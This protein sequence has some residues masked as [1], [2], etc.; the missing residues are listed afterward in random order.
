MWLMCSRLQISGVDG[1]RLFR[2]IYTIM[3]EFGHIVAQYGTATRGLQE[4]WDELVKLERDLRALMCEVGLCASRSCAH[5][6]TECP[7]PQL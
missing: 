3:D 2:Q 1:E 7:S 5:M 4:I 6:R